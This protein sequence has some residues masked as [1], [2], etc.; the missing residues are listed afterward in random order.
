MP[1]QI[2][3]DDTSTYVSIRIW[4]FRHYDIEN[5]TDI[6]YNPTG[7]AIMQKTNRT[8][9]EIFIEQREIWDLPEID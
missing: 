5:V 3:A 4:Y 6:S 2:E 1:L 8:L 9:K 7:Q